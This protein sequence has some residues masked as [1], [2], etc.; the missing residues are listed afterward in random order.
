MG[1]RFRNRH[2]QL[3][4]L[5]G[6]FE[7]ASSST[8]THTALAAINRMKDEGSE[9]FDE[10]SRWQRSCDELKE[11]LCTLDERRHSRGQDLATV[12]RE[13]IAE[14]EHSTHRMYQVLYGTSGT[15]DNDKNIQRVLAWFDLAYRLSTY[16][17]IAFWI[18]EKS[19]KTSI[20]LNVNLTTGKRTENRIHEEMKAPKNKIHKRG[21]KKL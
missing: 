18:D 21:A 4:D 2:F 6:R 16:A 5:A 3:F 12:L 14:F 10:G 9:F 8:H 20:H 17:I 1:E 13:F 19:D 7:A 15:P 11:F